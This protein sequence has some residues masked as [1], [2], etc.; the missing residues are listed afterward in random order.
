MEQLSIM[1]SPNLLASFRYAFAGIGHVLRTQRNLRIH[2]IITVI[3]IG[4]GL[5][6]GLSSLEWAAIIL[7]MGLVLTAEML[8]SAL[9]AAVD[10]ASPDPWPLAKVAKDTAAGAVMLAVFAAVIVG[11]LIIGSHLS[12]FFK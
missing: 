4:V 8:N 10:L 11:L 5:V 6:L 12:Q 9:E 2:L 7:A 1:R 3:I